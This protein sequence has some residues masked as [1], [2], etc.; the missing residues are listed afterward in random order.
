MMEGNKPAFFLGPDC[1]T[2]ARREKVNT[3]SVKLRTANNKQNNSV[4]TKS[5]NQQHHLY[6]PNARLRVSDSGLVIVTMSQPPL[7]Y[8]SPEVPLE[9][10]PWAWDDE[11]WIEDSLWSI[12]EGLETPSVSQA[13]TFMPPSDTCQQTSSTTESTFYPY[14]DLQGYNS[15]PENPLTYERPAHSF[16]SGS[17][18]YTHTPSLGFSPVPSQDSPHSVESLATTPN[19]TVEEPMDGLLPKD[20]QA[21]TESSYEQAQSHPAPTDQPGHS[22]KLSARRRRRK[23]KPVKCPIPGCG[24]G[25]AYQAELDR[26]IIAQHKDQAEQ[27][28][29]SVKRFPCPHCPR[30]F[31]RKDHLT[32]HRQ[33]RH[34]L[35]KQEKRRS[36]KK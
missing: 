23:E 5:Q 30:D 2:W 19:F 14:F 21:H 29:L 35:A 6:N 10:A 8:T 22:P 12:L 1:V 31:A 18:T 32:R 4:T 26:H 16:S 24:M 33:R 11:Q 7:Y 13:H 36:K 27:Y 25:H 9:E 20:P 3:A 15:L 28:A 34:G 17:P